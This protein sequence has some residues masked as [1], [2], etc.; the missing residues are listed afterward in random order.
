MYVCWL[1]FVHT[2]PQLVLVLSLLS[3]A[4]FDVHR[5]AFLNMRAAVL[6]FYNGSFDKGGYYRQSLFASNTST[7][8]LSHVVGA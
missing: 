5:W 8:A 6:S 2:L 4:S 7:H 1:D 3:I